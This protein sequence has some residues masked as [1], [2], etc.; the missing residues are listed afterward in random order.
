MHFLKKG[1]KIWA[2]SDR[3]SPPPL[4]RSMSKRKPY[5]SIDMFPSVQ[6]IQ[7]SRSASWKPISGPN[8][9]LKD[10]FLRL[11][12]TV[13]PAAWRKICKKDTSFPSEPLNRVGRQSLHLNKTKEFQIWRHLYLNDVKKASWGNHLMTSRFKSS[14]RALV[15]TALH[16]IKT[17][18]GRISQYYFQVLAIITVNTTII[19]IITMKDMMMVVVVTTWQGWLHGE[20]LL[21]ASAEETRSN[22][23]PLLDTWWSWS[24]RLRLRWWW[25]WWW[26]P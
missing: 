8:W 14:L 3:T 9:N 16:K 20:M 4:I 21:P 11:D 23:R 6:L 26:W 15:L 1:Q 5:F 12:Q 10:G 2:W 24:G 22:V 25:P 18:P 19:I 13:A 17:T 7:I